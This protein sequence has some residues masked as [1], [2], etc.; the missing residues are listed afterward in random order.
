LLKKQAEKGVAMFIW[1]FVSLFGFIA[2]LPLYFLSLEHLKLEE[3]YGGIKGKK[4][5]S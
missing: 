5:L 4:I 1:F 2:I 3:K